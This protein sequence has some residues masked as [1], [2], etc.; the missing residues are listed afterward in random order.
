MGHKT[1]QGYKLRALLYSLWNGKPASLFE[2]VALDFE[3]R[4]D[5]CAVALAF[6]FEDWRGTDSFFYEQI[7]LAVSKAGLWHWFLE[8][9]EAST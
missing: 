7:R 5:L 8:E 4:Q 9:A 6:G 2:I 1:G 3:I